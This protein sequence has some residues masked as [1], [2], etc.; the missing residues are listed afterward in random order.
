M[1]DARRGRDPRGAADRGIALRHALVVVLTLNAG[2]TDAIG[3]LALGGAFTSV[4]TGNLVL[5]GISLAEGDGEL[6]GHTAVAIVCFIAGC[7]LGA[8]VAG[9]PV[10]GQPVWPRAVTKALAIELVLFGGYAVGWWATGSHPQGAVQLVLL[11]VNAVALGMQSSSVQR[12]GVSG[13]STTY[14]TGTL[15]TLVI[16]LTS[17]HRVRDV[18]DS[19]LTLSGLVAGAVAAALLAEHARPFVPMIQLVCLA[20]VLAGAVP[21]SRVAAAGGRETAT[22]GGRQSD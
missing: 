14:M 11:A 7:V 4:M 2:A 6:A 1:V 22:F 17:G 10:A 3:F 5:L 18:S 8:R 12:F 13:L 15:T 16:R 20:V 9:T 19:L 21:P